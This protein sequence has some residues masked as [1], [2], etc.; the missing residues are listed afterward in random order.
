MPTQPT[1]VAPAAQRRAPRRG[2]T[3]KTRAV[4]NL[5]PPTPTRSLMRLFAILVDIAGS[6]P[7]TDGRKS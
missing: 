1:N 2:L 3:V 4:P 5:Q 7:I 6:A